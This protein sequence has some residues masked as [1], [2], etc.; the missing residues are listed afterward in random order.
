M[1]FDETRARATGTLLLDQIKV[2]R[3]LHGGSV[4]DAAL[5][6]LPPHIRQ[7]IDHALP[8]SW[9]P[10]EVGEAIH[11]AIAGELGRDPL[12]F[13]RELIRYALPRTFRT[14]WRVILR[15]TSDEALVAR[16]PMIFSKTY[17]RGKFTARIDTPGIASLRLMERPNA[18]DLELV[19]ISTAVETVLRLAG[20]RDV[21]VSWEK[22]PGG[23]SFLA[24][25]KA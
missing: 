15:F 18:S 11:T 25:W 23:A 9:V 17:D 24:T 7:E 1:T 8:T 22:T 2:S 16:C 19:G 20:R 4:V 12:D 10:Q 5:A 14:L 3:E 13:R 6:K 21:K